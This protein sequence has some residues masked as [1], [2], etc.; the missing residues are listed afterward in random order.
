MVCQSNAFRRLEYPGGAGSNPVKMK[1]KRKYYF[2]DLFLKFIALVSISLVVVFV[3]NI[4]INIL[5]I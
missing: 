3:L 5:A 1:K 4:T 2:I